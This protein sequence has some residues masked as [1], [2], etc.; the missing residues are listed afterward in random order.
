MNRPFLVCLLCMANCGLAA[1]PSPAQ[2]VD[3]T[4]R[5]VV[6]KDGSA[7][8]D[9][10]INY[11]IEP[12]TTSRANVPAVECNVG[13]DRFKNPQLDAA[14]NVKINLPLDSR[15]TGIGVLGSKYGMDLCGGVPQSVREVVTRGVVAAANCSSKIKA[16]RHPG[17]FVLFVRPLTFR[18]R[19]KAF[20]LGS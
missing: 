13:P 6:A 11:G 17:E 14:G 18:E 15:L 16:E 3:I 5:F 19:I 10:F 7:L 1:R 2:C 12:E 20:W 4:I 8:R 9:K